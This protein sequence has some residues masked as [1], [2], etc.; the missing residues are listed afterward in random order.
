MKI[1][2]I[3]DRHMIGSREEIAIDV[4]IECLKRKKKI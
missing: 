2:L 1:L 3:Y 4:T